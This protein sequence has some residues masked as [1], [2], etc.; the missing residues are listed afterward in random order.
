MLNLTFEQDAFLK[1]YKIPISFIYDATWVR[2][3]DFKIIMKDLWKKVAIWVNPCWKCSYSIKDRHNHCLFCHP[4]NLSFSTRNDTYAYVYVAGSLKENILKV[5]MTEDLQ[6]RKKHLN[7]NKY[8][9]INDWE[10]L[11]KW[12]YKNSG[13]IETFVLSE[14]KEYLSNTTYNYYWKEQ[15][16]YETFS[17]SF[18]TVRKI[19]DNMNDKIYAVTEE[20][21]LPDALITYDFENKILNTNR[22]WK[23]KIKKKAK[24]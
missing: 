20:Y 7:D 11:Y 9:W 18:R 6:D 12:K 3:K 14:L 13:D 5:W 21:Y 4:E 23:I 17:C 24:L 16:C 8:W 19:I 15:R 1:K 22:S 2:P 10:I